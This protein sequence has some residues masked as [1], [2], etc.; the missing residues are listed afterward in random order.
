MHISD[1]T[2]SVALADATLLLAA[3]PFG[4]T[5]ARTWV[6]AALGWM[7]RRLD[8]CFPQE[9]VALIALFSSI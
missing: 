9:Q 7:D 3:N 6:V 2:Y 1:T 5:I 4:A 8:H